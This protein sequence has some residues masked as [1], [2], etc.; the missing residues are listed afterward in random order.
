M[1]YLLDASLSYAEQR[2]QFG[3]P[4]STFQAVQHHLAL[5]A[6][7]VASV[8]AAVDAAVHSAPEQRLMMV[9]AAKTILGEQAALLTRLA[10]QVHGAIGA[11][12][13]HPIQSRT[14][15]LWSWQDEFGT[16]TDWAVEL[17]DQLVFPKS[18]GAWQ[19]LTPPLPALESRDVGERVP[20]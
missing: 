3:R 1:E 10:H 4:I 6:E 7:A 13:E 18:P 16:T 5:I 8:S 20:W 9:A 15:R 19:V 14:R 11:T 2:H 17:A 12:A